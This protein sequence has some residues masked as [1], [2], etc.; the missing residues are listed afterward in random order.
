MH[1]SA[2]KSHGV[3]I[4]HKSIKVGKKT[5][6]GCLLLGQVARRRHF[7]VIKLFARCRNKRCRR[8]RRHRP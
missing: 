3:L 6:V 5:R 8:V 4:S 1:F 2:L 7:N